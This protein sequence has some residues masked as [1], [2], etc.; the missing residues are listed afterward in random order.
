[1]HNDL[2]DTGKLILRLTLGILILLHGIAKLTHGIE[3]IEGMVTSMGMPA[4]VA[5]GVYVGEVVGPLLLIIG[6]YARI[7]AA[8]IAINMLFAIALAH[9]S[10]LTILTQTGGWAL[11]LQGMFLFTAIALMVMGPGRFGVNQR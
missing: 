4:F 3:P 1:M 11:E 5:Y 2:N 8:L 10:E 7:G 9:T 6:F